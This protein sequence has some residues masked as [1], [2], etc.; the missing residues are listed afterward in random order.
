MV[1]CRWRCVAVA[2]VSDSDV[3]AV[4]LLEYIRERYLCVLNGHQVVFV[5]EA[6]RQHRKVFGP[7]Q[8]SPAEQARLLS[9]LAAVLSHDSVNRIGGLLDAM[10]GETIERKVDDE[11]VH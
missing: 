4:F 7:G 10:A 11:I 8:P 1:W 6:I 3:A 2:T 5:D 9:D